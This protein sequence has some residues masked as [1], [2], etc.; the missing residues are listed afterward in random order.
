MTWLDTIILSI[1]EGVTEFLPI[2]STGHMIITDAIMNHGKTPTES[3]REFARLFEVCIQLGAILSVVTL[4]WRKFFDIKRLDLY[5][6]LIV[7][8]FPALAFGF[9]F[10]KKIDE[11]LESPATVAV[12]LLLGGIVLLFVDNL[13]SAKNRIENDGEL[14]YKKGFMIGMWQ[15]LAMIPGTSRSA[16]TII[17]G[18]QQGLTR[19][20]AAEF[21]FFLAVPTMMAA[22]GYK[23]LKAT[24]EHPELLKDKDNLAMLGVGNII[25]FVVALVAIKTFIGFLQKNSL[26]AFG[27]Y[28]IVAAIIIFGLMYA[29]YIKG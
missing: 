7:A 21:S 27:V 6:K 1:V 20:F 5:F 26:R 17:G 14:S 3:E 4:Y 19:R 10:S 24:K 29:G 22:T 13:F 18:M 11:L 23:L 25:A 28:R 2:S 16:A 9:L 12:A 8:V 15:V